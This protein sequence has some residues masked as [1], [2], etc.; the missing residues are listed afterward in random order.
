MPNLFVTG[1]SAFPQNAGYNPTGTVAALA[2]LV[3]RRHPRQV[4]EKSGT[5]GACVDRAASQR[6]PACAAALLAACR[7]SRR[8]NADQQD[9]AQI[10]RGRYLVTAAD[11]AACHTRPDGG[12]AVC[13]RTADR[14][15]VRQRHCAPTSRPTSE[16]GIGAWTDDEF[17]DAVREGIRPDG[18][19]LYPAMP[20]TSYTKMTRDDVL[21]IHAYL[22]TIA[23]VHN[24]VVPTSCRSRSTS[25]SACG[26][27]LRCSSSRARFKPDPQNRPNGIAAPISSRARA[28]AAPA[29]RR[30][31]SLG[32]DKSGELLQ[33]ANLQGWFAP[34]ITNDNRR[35]LGR[36]S[37]ED[38]RR[39]I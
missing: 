27:G 2:Y 22:S 24:E 37:V 26:V 13:R 32:G 34:D 31:T 15:A 9:F 30:R 1:A 14:D 20:Y 7:S 23:P 8:A 10:E 16:T 33:G 6:S 11:C 21:A 3:G 35:G 17:D 18:S 29:T 38:D 28:I 5:A 4:S 12:A 39:H 36:W 25:A 19:R